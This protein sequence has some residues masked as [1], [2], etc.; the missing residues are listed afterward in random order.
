[1]YSMYSHLQSEHPPDLNEFWKCIN[2]KTANKKIIYCIV[3]VYIGGSIHGNSNTTVA[4]GCRY[5]ELK[6]CKDIPQLFLPQYI[7]AAVIFN[8]GYSAS[9]L[10]GFTLY[11]KLF[12]PYPQ[13]I[14]PFFCV[15]KVFHPKMF[16]KLNSTSLWMP[17]C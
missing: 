10:P 4:V 5:P 1:M 11:S 15:T 13:V 16:R 2:N 6:W 8:I 17:Q 7:A 12:G 3:I 14:K 9:L